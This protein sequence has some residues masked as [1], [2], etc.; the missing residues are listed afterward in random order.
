MLFQRPTWLLPPCVFPSSG[1]GTSPRWERVKI[2]M[3]PWAARGRQSPLPIWAN[4]PIRWCTGR[5]TKYD[6]R[7]NKS[8]AKKIGF[9]NFV[10]STMTD[11]FPKPENCSISPTLQSYL[12]K[13]FKICQN[14]CLRL[15]SQ[16]LLW[17]LIMSDLTFALK[18][19]TIPC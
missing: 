11:R 5:S 13:N 10:T 9:R 14:V 18:V 6:W 19:S 3:P 1:R 16:V 2:E 17:H 4:R 7:Q 8:I 12:I 15:R